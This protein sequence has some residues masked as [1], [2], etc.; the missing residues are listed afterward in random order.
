MRDLLR[1][2]EGFIWGTSTGGH[3][4]EGDNEYSDWWA[5]EKEGLVHDGTTSGRSVDYWRRYEED[6]AL[7]ARLDYKG[8]RLGIEW[9]RVEPEPGRYDYNVIETYRNI[10][11][12]LTRSWHRTAAR[13]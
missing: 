13:T 11:T 2:P 10:L 6:H 1:F 9:A 12:S 7:M 3:Q 8:F 4:V 5:W